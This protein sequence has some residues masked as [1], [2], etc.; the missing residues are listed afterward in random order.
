M[1]EEVISRLFAYHTAHKTVLNALIA[2][3]P[4]PEFLLEAL[5]HYAEAPNVAM[6]NSTFPEV[7][8]AQYEEELNTFIALAEKY[9]QA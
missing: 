5:T 8:I 9:I 3:H 4:Q 6:L 1:N 7:H 2:S